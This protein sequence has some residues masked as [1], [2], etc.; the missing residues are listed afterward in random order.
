M[1][2][3]RTALAA[4]LALLTGIATLAACSTTPWQV[5]S[6]T[7]TGNGVACNTT[8]GFISKGN[9]TAHYL[10]E[11]EASWPFPNCAI[12]QVT[13]VPTGSPPPSGNIF[14]DTIIN[15]DSYPGSKLTWIADYQLPAPLPTTPVQQTFEIVA[16]VAAELYPSLK[17][18]NQGFPVVLGNNVDVA[19]VNCMF[20]PGAGPMGPN[21]PQGQINC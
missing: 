20:Y 12:A 7:I 18:N 6:V 4:R 3:S 11:I 13:V 8:T 5:S 15:E 2:R 17:N 9:T 16:F 19:T 10:P 1:T 21:G 14:L